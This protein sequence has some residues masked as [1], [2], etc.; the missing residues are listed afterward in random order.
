MPHWFERCAR[1]GML[2]TALLVAGCASMTEEECLTADW[3]ERGVRDGRNGEPRSYLGDHYEACAK[4]G[5]VPVDADYYR[6]HSK[7]VTQYCTPDNGA[8]MGRAGRSYRN[9]CPVELEGPFLQA[10]RPAYRVYQAEQRINTLN[11]N[12]QSK[13]RE[14]DREKDEDKRR[15]IRRELRDLDDRLRQARKDMHYAER[16]QYRY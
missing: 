7:G 14:L 9:A 4:V 5:V 13:E 6:G 15:R 11:N 8:R 12:I 2:A 1:F 10:Y 16:S 3:Y